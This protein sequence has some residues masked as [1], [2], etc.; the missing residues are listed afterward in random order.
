MV[1]TNI[2]RAKNP[3]TC[4]YHG[5]A[6]LDK[7]AAQ[8]VPAVEPKTPIENFIPVVIAPTV[9]NLDERIAGKKI[10]FKTVHGSRLY[11][12][13]HK[14]SDE[15]YYVVTDD[16]DGKLRPLQTIVDGIDTMRLSFSAFEKMAIKGVPQVLEAMFSKLT[17]GDP[18]EAYRK[19]YR[20][21]D[22]QVVDTYMRTI[23][24][25]ALSEHFK[26]RRHAIRLVMNLNDI[27]RTERFD[28]T[29]TPEEAILITQ[30]TNTSFDEYVDY[31]NEISLLE[32]NWESTLEVK[33]ES[34]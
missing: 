12:L 30:K 18:I 34:K 29:L 27:L 7:Q 14:D 5:L 28:P 33:P 13:S 1:N 23:K 17:T 22:P 9:Q 15:D 24:N 6:Q 3:L 10:V 2:C 11:G 26:R 21:S 4:P 32:I 19:G 25:F 31:I 20:A 8:P 16:A